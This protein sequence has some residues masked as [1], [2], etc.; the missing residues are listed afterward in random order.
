[1]SDRDIDSSVV[2]DQFEEG[3]NLVQISVCWENR[4]METCDPDSV[5][6]EIANVSVTVQSNT[7]R[8][9]PYGE[10]TRDSS[11]RDV[12]DGSVPIYPPNAVPFFSNYYGSLHV[13]LDIMLQHRE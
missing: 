3:E 11:F 12:L 13:S 8:L 7:G 1:M 5:T 6:V 4:Q 2:A 9:F 10:P